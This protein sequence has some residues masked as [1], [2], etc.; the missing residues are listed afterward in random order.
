MLVGKEAKLSE[1]QLSELALGLMAHDIGKARVPAHILKSASRAKHEEAFYRDHPKYGV[2]LATIAGV[3]SPLAMTVISD[4]HECLDGS[5]WPAGKS[6]LGP[7]A[8]IGAIVDRYDRLCSP[9]AQGAAALTPSEALAQ[10]FKAE[11]G[12]YDAYLFKILIRLLGVYPPGS[13]VKLSDESLALVVSPGRESLRPVVLIYNPDLKKEDAP[14]MDLGEND[15]IKIVEAIRPSSLPDDVV[16]WLNPRQRL[17]YFYS[18]ERA[19]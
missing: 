15:E 2:E 1:S 6:A 13:I 18:S 17:S 4:H 19:S 7:A 9:E 3:F 8:R 12:K 16:A 10:L 14:T 11:S 5:G